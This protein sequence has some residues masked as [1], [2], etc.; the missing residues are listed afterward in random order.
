MAE[1]EQAIENPR[2]MPP[3]P[4]TEH[5]GPLFALAG[6][7]SVIVSFIYDWGFFSTLGIDFAQAPTT[8]SDHLRSWVV[9]LPFV[10]TPVFLLLAHE[11]LVSRLERGLTEEEIIE[12]SR[13]PARVRRFRVGP[14]KAI[15]IMAL[16]LTLLWILFGEMFS[17]ARAF[18]FPITWAI[19]AQWVFRHPRLDADY[20]S[21][22]KNILTYI[23]AAFFFVFFLGAS[24]AEAE[25]SH[26]SASH[27][28]ELAT[29]AQ[30]ERKTDVRLLRSFQDWI[31]LRDEN[32]KVTWV[33]LND[34]TRIQ[35]LKES[36]MFKGFA[37][38]YSTSWCLSKARVE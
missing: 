18:A 15:S 27:R 34:V 3:R 32:G 31:L 16:L 2:E 24:I 5:L 8:I 30:G 17:H 26:S 4:V 10:I 19:F 25:M 1:R 6:S 36:E 33:H 22:I 28:I 21:A 37:C 29:T 13:N 35:M 7:V 9:W 12:S 20:S 23:P 11:L 14:K 38:L